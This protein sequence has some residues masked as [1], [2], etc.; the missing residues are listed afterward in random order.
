MT[1]YSTDCSPHLSQQTLNII[2]IIIQVGFIAG[3]SGYNA[4]ILG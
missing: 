3:P 2:M 1:I 4:L